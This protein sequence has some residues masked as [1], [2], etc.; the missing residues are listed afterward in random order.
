MVNVRLVPLLGHQT[1]VLAEAWG[2]Q[3]ARRRE[4]PCYFST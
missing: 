3:G 4:Y 2:A 1:H